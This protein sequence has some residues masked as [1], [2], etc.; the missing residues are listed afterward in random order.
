MELSSRLKLGGYVSAIL[1]RLA[2][3]GVIVEEGA[4]VRLPTH[5]IELSEAQQAKVAAFLRSL[6][7]EPYTPPSELIPEP[8]L[9][10][11]LIEQHKVVKVIDGVVFS[12]SAYNEMVEK[13]TAYI[14]AHGKVNVAEVRD[15]FKTSRKYALPFLEY[16]DQQKIT[17]RTG[18]ERVLY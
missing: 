3:Q 4:A 8:D 6:S 9:L 12:T 18:D 10:N 13:V 11:L 15:L 16:L 7:Q 17:R 2:D 5:R 14:K 1:Q